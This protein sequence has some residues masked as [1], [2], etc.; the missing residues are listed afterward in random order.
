MTG[1][2]PKTIIGSFE[3]L[4]KDI[5]HEVSKLP[6]DITG[7]AL[8]SL[9]TAKSKTSG[10]T[11][12]TTQFIGQADGRPKSKDAFD[13]IDETGDQKNK[14][15]IARAALSALL[16][17]PKQAPETIWDQ[18]QKEDKEKKDALEFQKKEQKKTE[19]PK[20]TYR[21]ARGD[22]YGLAAK[23][24]GAEMSKNVRQD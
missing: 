24:Q 21:R 23:K 19:L 20:S 7:A 11:P 6:T 16:E 3:D 9:G 15:A 18:K 13:K 5:I 1:N 8:E 22:L 2:L 10:Q 12:K 4:G 14:Q 17:R